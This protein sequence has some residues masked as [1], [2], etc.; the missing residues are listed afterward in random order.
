LLFALLTSQPNNTNEVIFTMM[1]R[2]SY[3]LLALAVC[4]QAQTPAPSGSSFPSSVP[5]GSPSY[6]AASEFPSFEPTPFEDVAISGLQ[7]DPTDCP[8][9]REGG[10][11]VC[12]E[13]LC[14]TNPT[15]IF[16][17]P[18]QP[19]VSCGVLEAAGSSGIVPTDQCP[20]L[21][22]LVETLCGC[23][24]ALPAP[25]T[26]AAPVMPTSAPIAP[27]PAPVMATPAPVTPAPVGPTP[28]P[29]V[30]AGG[31]TVCGDGLCVTKPG[32]IFSFAGQPEVPC[33][34]LQTAGE[35]G[36][37]PP[38]Q[39]PFLPGIIVDLCGCES[40]IPAPPSAAPVE[41]TLAPV[42]PSDSPV[43]LT[44]APIM[45]PSPVSA[46]T[47]SPSG[48]PFPSGSSLPSAQPSVSGDKGGKSM[49][50]PKSMKVA[51]AMVKKADKIVRRSLNTRS[52]RGV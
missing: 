8:A 20:F 41:P 34:V 52:I 13:G 47:S 32:A 10:C 6:S 24:S 2:F 35:V 31:C 33:S 51:M 39:C 49:K 1:M 15:A 28:C 37:V 25:P 42:E 7:F 21:P 4:A 26:T 23:A 18:S 14:V 12:G 11:S 46:E 40:S 36:Q 48:S 44:A 5:S 50:T 30:P 27:S 16:A 19:D 38:N 43:E 22:G 3:P 17:F 9:I 29:V 45:T